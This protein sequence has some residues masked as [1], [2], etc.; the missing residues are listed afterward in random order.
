MA[1]GV[2]VL[3]CFDLFFVFG[4]IFVGSIEADIHGG[5]LFSSPGNLTK[6]VV[7]FKAHEGAVA[8]EG[9]ALDVMTARERIKDAKQ[10][11]AHDGISTVVAGI[12][13]GDNA[14]VVRAELPCNFLHTFNRCAASLRVLLHGIAK[15]LFTQKFKT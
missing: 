9:A 5:C 7:S 4:R 14:A 3:A 13:H 12:G 10:P 8:V 11:G 6:V 15:G 1:G 2:G